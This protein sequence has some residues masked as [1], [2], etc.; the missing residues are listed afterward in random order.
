MALRLSGQTAVSGDA[1]FMSKTLAGIG[2]Q[3]ELRKF[4]IFRKPWN[5]VKILIYRTAYLV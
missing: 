1:F 3:N 4:E 2:R 5:H